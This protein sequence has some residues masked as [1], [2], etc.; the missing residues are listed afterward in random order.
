MGLLGQRDSMLWLC[1]V[2]VSH[3]DENYFMLGIYNIVYKQSITNFQLQLDVI[4]FNNYLE[5]LT[6]FLDRRVRNYPNLSLSEKSFPKFEV[7]IRNFPN[8]EVII[9]KFWHILL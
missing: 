2:K 9:E 5:L 6:V 3:F 8:F 1:R 4:D 7:F